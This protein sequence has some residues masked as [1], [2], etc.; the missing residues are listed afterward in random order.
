MAVSTSPNWGTVMQ[1]VGQS[2]VQTG[3]KVGSQG[4]GRG[5]NDE[6]M[7]IGYQGREAPAVPRVRHAP[8][9]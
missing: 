4:I 6:V 3:G 1:W 7:G 5:P 2:C 9:E 8:G